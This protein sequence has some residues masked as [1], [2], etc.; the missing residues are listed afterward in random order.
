[1]ALVGKDAGSVWLNFYAGHALGNLTF[2]PLA[3]LIVRG[4]VG[5]TLK[6]AT[7]RDT[8]ETVTLLALVVVVSMYVFLQANLPLL[9]VPVLPIILM[10]FRLGRGGAAVAIALLALIG[11]GAT[12]AG[13]GPIELIDSDFAS[14][15]QFFQFYLAATVLTVLPVAAD[16]ENRRRLH[17]DLRVSE[18]RYRLLAEHSTDIILQ[19]DRQG[20]IRF[21]SPSIRQL[22]GHDPLKLVGRSSLILIA[23]EHLKRV[24]HDHAATIAAAGRTHTYEYLALTGDG[25]KRWFESHG[26]AIFDEWGAVE[27]VLS[28]ARDISARKAVERR[29]TSD[30][31]TDALTGL[32]NRRALDSTVALRPPGA[33]E[34]ARDCIAVLDL[35]HFKVIND[36]FGHSVGDR[37]LRDFAKLARRMIRES[38]MIARIGGEEFAIFFPDTPIDQALAVCDRLRVE[39]ANTDF[40][41]GSATVRITVSG[42]V[43]RIGPEGFERALRIADVALYEAKRNGRDQFALAA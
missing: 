6:D 34:D 27:S 36:S 5:K 23:P 24:R 19:L 17:R 32:P 39:M 31:L 28:I 16:L 37:V 26:R 9:F 10:T 29:L 7:R 14:Q 3:L 40:R 13:V 8:L 22:G 2:T 20:R 4:N 41:A 35:D 25:S 15:M 33:I 18:E 38:D 30:A 42:G 21:V 12:L 1:M 11:G 43:G